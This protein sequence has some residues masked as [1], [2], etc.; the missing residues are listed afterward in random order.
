[1]EYND[2]L[3]SSAKQSDHNLDLRHDFCFSFLK[4]FH[5]V[6]LILPKCNVLDFIHLVSI[7]SM[8]TYFLMLHLSLFC[9]FNATF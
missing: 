6:L 8:N 9:L 3:S 2:M 5:L 4:K 1:M 7:L